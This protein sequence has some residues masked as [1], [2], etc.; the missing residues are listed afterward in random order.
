MT[1]VVD[2]KV[3]LN[4]T[5]QPNYKQVSEQLYHELLATVYEVGS[6]TPTIPTII[7]V[8]ELVKK[9]MLEQG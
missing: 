1:N 7:G 4:T 9:D 2:L 8:L 3:H 6:G 5:K